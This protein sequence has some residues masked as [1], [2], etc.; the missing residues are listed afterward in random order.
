M[1]AEAQRESTTLRGEGDAQAAQIYAQAYSQDPEF[2]AF[3]RSLEA[4]EEALDKDT[5][6][7]LSP[8]LPFLK[9]F[10]SNQPEPT[11]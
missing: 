4:Y 9:Y 7:I 10:F 5:T 6:I 1:R 8:K 2:Y 11:R 3:M